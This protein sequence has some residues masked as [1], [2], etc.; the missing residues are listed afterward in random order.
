MSNERLAARLA[1]EVNA[2]VDGAFSC[3]E[4]LQPVDDPSL[5]PWAYAGL[6]VS[7]LAGAGFRRHG[8]V[9][10]VLERFLAVGPILSPPPWIWPE[11]RL[12]FD[13]ARIA[14]CCIA[15]GVTFDRIDLVKDGLRLLAWVIDHEL[16]GDHLMCGE[17]TLIRS[18][19]SI[20]C[21]SGR[22]RSSIAEWG[23][24]RATRL[25][26][27]PKVAASPTTDMLA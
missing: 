18:Q 8:L 16:R 6:G 10:S 24:S 20:P 26:A 2:F 17:S 19:A 23:M 27:S 7:L 11:E 15:L 5:R 13:N 25:I 12:A 22:L 3:L 1:V 9:E 21:P 4:R 14:E